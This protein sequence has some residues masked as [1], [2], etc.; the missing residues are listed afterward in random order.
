MNQYD[1]GFFN[2][3]WL[4]Q[5]FGENP[6]LYTAEYAALTHPNAFSADKAKIAIESLLNKERDGFE[7]VKGEPFSHDN[8]TAV[9][10]LSKLYNLS[11]HTKFF[12]KHWWRRAHPR[13]WI[14]YLSLKE[15]IIGRIAGL[16]MFIP[17]MCMIYGLLFD[18]YKIIDGQRVLATD[19][20]LLTYLRLSCC[21]SLKLTQKLCHA[22]LRYRKV[23]WSD[24]FKIYFGQQHPNY[25]HSTRFLR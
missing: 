12:W 19:G 1:K 14:F 5:P 24:Y 18:H 3:E 7:A 8:M 15:G 20:K 6:I 23:N 4:M 9:V 17:S 16:F 21:T 22:I 10:C 25:I 2:H 13:D 11:Y